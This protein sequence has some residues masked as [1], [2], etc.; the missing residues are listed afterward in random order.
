MLSLE[1]AMGCSVATSTM[2]SSGSSVFRDLLAGAVR[3]PFHLHQHILLNVL[4]KH[5]PQ[6]QN[7][8]NHSMVPILPS[9]EMSS[10]KSEDFF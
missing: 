3:V 9:S 6:N 1:A 8:T 7:Q 2:T 4:K 5:S 10:H